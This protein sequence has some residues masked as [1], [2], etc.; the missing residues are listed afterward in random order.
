MWK[1]GGGGGGRGMLHVDFKKCLMSLSLIF[2]C[3]VNFEKNTC[4]LCLLPS[5][6]VTLWPSL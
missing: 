1:G 5:L 3:L 2:S 6:T 4:H